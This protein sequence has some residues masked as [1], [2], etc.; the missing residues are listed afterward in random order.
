MTRR[1]S[2]FGA[3]G[4]IGQNTLDLIRRDRAGT[5]VVALTGGRNVAQLAADAREFGAEIAVTS[6]HDRSVPPCY[7]GTPLDI[8]HEWASDFSGESISPE[9]AVQYVLEDLST[10]LEGPVGLPE[11][12]P[13][14]HK[15][16]LILGVLLETDLIREVPMVS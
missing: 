11:H 6:N 13:L 4:S 7:N 3:T 12:L 8:I 1:I 16:A 15:A 9:V 2:V 5:R 14:N 10:I